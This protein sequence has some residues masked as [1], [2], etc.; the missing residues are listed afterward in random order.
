MR[1]PMELTDAIAKYGFGKIGVAY[2]KEDGYIQSELFEYE[3]DLI[4]Y[5]DKT[6]GDTELFAYGLYVSFDNYFGYTVFYLDDYVEDTIGYC[7]QST[8]KIEYKPKQ[9]IFNTLY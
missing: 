6:F 5:L 7:A 9:I 2:S 4:E 3:D 1:V 8:N